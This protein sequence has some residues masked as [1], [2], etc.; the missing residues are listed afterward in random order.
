[1]KRLFVIFLYLSLCFPASA[2]NLHALLKKLDRVIEQKNEYSSLKRQRIASLREGGFDSYELCHALFEEYYQ[3]DKDSEY[4]YATKKVAIAKKKGNKKDYEE[5]ILNLADVYTLAGMYSEAKKAAESVSNHDAMY[6]H[7]LH[8][9]YSALQKSSALEDK[10]Q[11]YH[12]K[13]CRYRDSLISS[14]PAS[15]VGYVFALSE[16]LNEQGNFFEAIAIL[17]EKKNDNSTPESSK[18]A[19]DFSLAVAYQGMGNRKMAETYYA[20]SAIADIQYCIRDYRSLH[21]LA[22]ML[23]ED[24]EM[25]RAYK[26][27]SC[28][29]E[30]FKNSNVKVR[31][32]EFYPLFSIITDAY[33]KE[34]NKKNSL[35]S[36]CLIILS[37]LLSLIVGISIKMVRQRERIKKSKDELDKS[38]SDLKIADEKLLEISLELQEAGKIKEEY[39]YRFMEY[40]GNYIDQLEKYRRGLYLTYKKFGEKML[41]EELQKPFD[42]KEEIHKFYQSFDEAFLHLFPNFIQDVNSLL[43]PDYQLQPKADRLMNTELRILA[44]IRLGVTDSVQMSHFL[45]VSLSTIY[46][47]RTKLRNYSN[48]ERAEFEERISKIGTINLK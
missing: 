15:D 47:Y 40:T 9:L 24:G 36:L 13:M 45:R 21:L 16:K 5:S 4:Y 41:A 29:M 46:N 44:L 23:F 34:V 32:D 19:I 22:Y 35:L 2:Q 31:A 39:L 11:E 42:I 3:Y 8:A 20:M 38:Y 10:E 14:L 43:V 18:P 25:E 1:M 37:V 30:D 28:A 33:Q 27:I 26:Y 7:V 17:I 6:Y 48:C 12:S